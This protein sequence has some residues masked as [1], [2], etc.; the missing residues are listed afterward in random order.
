MK[1]GRKVG[2]NEGRKVGS[3]ERRKKGRKVGRNERKKVSRKGARK[4]G[5]KEGLYDT[6][7]DIR[8]PRTDNIIESMKHTA[9][10]ATAQVDKSIRGKERGGD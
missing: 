6:K 8:C 5:W 9:N 2:R 4:E 7:I 10:T 3:K 1:E